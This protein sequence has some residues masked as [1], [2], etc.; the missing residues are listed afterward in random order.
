MSHRHWWLFCIGECALII[1]LMWQYRFY[2]PTHTRFT[3]LNVGQGDS[4]LIQTK[5]GQRVLVDG[6]PDRSVLPELDRQ[7]PWFDRRIDLMVLTHSDRD[8]LFGL[9]EVLRRYDVGT[10][11]FSGA[12]KHDSR[13]QEFLELIQAEHARVLIADPRTDIRLDSE[14]VLDVLW[15]AP[16]WVGK[17][18]KDPNNTSV[19]LRLLTTGN[20]VLMTGDNELT[21]ELQLL[22]SGV[23]LQADILKVG[24]HG[25][26]TSTATG[27]LLAVRPSMAVI[28]APK[29]SPYGH[30]HKEVVDRLHWANVTTHQTGL[31]GSVSFDLSE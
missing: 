1:L 30:P 14:T 18:P 2:V 19:T 15:P 9:P 11:L 13:Y 20:S 10:V 4:L 3:A 22:R 29:K 7:L 16:V 8:H 26:K 25:S 24:H 5:S 23:P 21:T 6:G 12:D 31:E 28:S 27:F 17:I